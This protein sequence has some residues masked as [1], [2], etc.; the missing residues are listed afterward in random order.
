MAAQTAITLPVPEFLVIGDAFLDVQCGGLA[1]LPRWDADELVPRPIEFL[2]GG[3]G[4]NTACHL[5]RAGRRVELRCAL[6]A[7]DAGAKLRS[8]AA[9]A[10]VAVVPLAAPAGAATGVCV[11]LSGSSDR[12]FATHRGAVAVAGL[13]DADI[14]RAREVGARGGHVHIAGYYNM[15]AV[16]ARVGE[17]FRAVREAGG[18]SSLNPQWDADER[19]GGIGELSVAGGTA[20]DVLIASKG[21][22]IQLTARE[23][24]G[25]GA[26]LTE[27]EAVRLNVHQQ[28]LKRLL[29][30]G[31]ARCVVITS[32]S[33]GA[34]AFYRLGTSDLKQVDMHVPRLAPDALVDAT[35]AGDAFAAGFLTKFAVRD[36]SIDLEDALRTGC[37]YGGTCCGVVGA[38]AA[39]DPGRVAEYARV[40]RE[41]VL[42]PGQQGQVSWSSRP[43]RPPSQ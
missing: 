18:S 31:R 15:P 35:G 27:T 25:A 2:A 39:L 13:S 10:G 40:C 23:A 37:A 4:L 17:L 28:G 11:V 26:R 24:P 9:D 12:A 3:G 22:Q 21:E 16:R 20:P 42:P 6:G 14:E 33:Q 43:R 36:P 8:A 32:G 7:D 1:Q 41:V 30:A 5:A 38:S 29:D 34:S 19:W